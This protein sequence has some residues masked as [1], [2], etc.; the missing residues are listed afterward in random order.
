MINYCGSRAPYYIDQRVA[1]AHLPKRIVPLYH[2]IKTQLA[3][4]LLASLCPACR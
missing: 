2:T 4:Q 3:V 1:E